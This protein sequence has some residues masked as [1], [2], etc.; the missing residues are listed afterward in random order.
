M[1][2]SRRNFF[3]LF[4]LLGLFKKNFRKKLQF[5]VI[6]LN[7]NFQFNRE[8]LRYKALQMTFGRG[9]LLLQK[10]I[11]LPKRQEKTNKVT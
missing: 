1:M 10:Y 4:R 9:P 5:A 3:N 2:L 8:L 6:S 11:I 7:F